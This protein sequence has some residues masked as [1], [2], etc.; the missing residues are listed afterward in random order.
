LRRSCG[1]AGPLREMMAT[2][3]H[4]TLEG[5]T[6]EAPGSVNFHTPAP[7]TN[8]EAYFA[9][10][11]A[12]LCIR[13]DFKLAGAEGESE[14]SPSSESME[15][16]D[17]PGMNQGAWKKHVW[18]TEE[19][20]KLLECINAAAGKVRWSVVGK[21]MDGR[22]GKQ[23]RERWHNH[24]S[25]DVRK[26]KWS[27]EE[28]RAIVEAVQ[29]YG[30]RWSE[31][32]KMFPGRTDNA[33]KNRWNSMLRKEDRRVKRI[34][35]EGELPPAGI[36]EEAKRR[37]RL[38]QPCDLQPVE[39]L[40]HPVPAGTAPAMGSALMQQLEEVGVAAP[41]VKPGGR[42]KR[43]VQARV[44][45]DAASLLLGTISKINDECADS[46]PTTSVPTHGRA[47]GVARPEDTVRAI[48]YHPAVST[49]VNA[50]ETPAPADSPASD[51][52]SVADASDASVPIATVAFPP[53]SSFISETAAPVSVPRAVVKVVPMPP[54]QLPADKENAP[55]EKETLESPRRFSRAFKSHSPTAPPQHVLTPSVD[56]PC[57]FKASRVATK[58]DWENLELAG[59]NSTF[60]HD[61]LEAALAIQALQGLVGM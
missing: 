16:D 49:S 4:T 5:V 47:M 44:D 43:A 50:E 12:T 20:A 11:K 51:M 39:A 30:T 42:R 35:D 21:H 27:A 59:S 23:C 46:T 17:S 58:T 29:L 10:T 15:D 19:D 26:S 34:L 55:T 2:P 56:S 54:M 41:V 60:H 57:R 38:V 61:R 53:P 36:S 45:M 28:D 48:A 8:E 22:S 40:R 24:L 9:G 14:Q 13:A 31:I 52:P 1:R 18:T 7:A 25:P 3:M 37:R 33:I 6:P 32:V